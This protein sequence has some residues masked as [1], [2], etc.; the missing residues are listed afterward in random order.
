MRWLIAL[1]LVLNLATLA[2]QWDAFARWGWGPH[3]Q[4]EPERLLQQIRPEALKIEI[5]PAPLPAEAS[6]AANPS[7][8]T[9][10]AAAEPAAPVTG[11]AV[12]DAGQ[13]PKTAHP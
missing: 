9:P 11:A 6:S 10:P 3:T 5:P 7:A 12:P 1:L 2:W 8:A 4:Q 13:T